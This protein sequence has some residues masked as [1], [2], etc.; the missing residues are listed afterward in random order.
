MTEDNKLA[1]IVE[2]YPVRYGYQGAIIKKKNV[3]EKV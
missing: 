1:A 3:I 2:R